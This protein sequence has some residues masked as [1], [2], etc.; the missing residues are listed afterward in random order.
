MANLTL[1]FQAKEGADPVA[2]AKDL[3]QQLGILPSVGSAE[4][5]ADNYR[6]PLGPTEIIAAI[7]LAVGVIQSATVAAQ[8]LTK[9]IDAVKGLV[10][11]GQGLH[12]AF[13]E[14]GMRKVPIDKLTP[15]DI[16]SLAG[17]IASA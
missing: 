4:A 11:S 12:A 5:R 8:A 16:E 14:V 6:S 3:E 15:Q 1:H 13:V 10:Q 17:R 7:T 9:L 2:S